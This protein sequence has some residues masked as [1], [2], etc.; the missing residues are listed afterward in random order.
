MYKRKKNKAKL[1]KK[2]K[3]GATPIIIWCE[4]LKAPVRIKVNSYGLQIK[5]KTPVLNFIHQMYIEN[6]IAYKIGRFCK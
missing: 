2:F 1:F 4:N 6:E 5:T 3:A